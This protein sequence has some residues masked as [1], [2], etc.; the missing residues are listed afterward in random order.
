MIAL[1][2]WAPLIAGLAAPPLLAW[3]ITLGRDCPRRATRLIALAL[4]L[5]LAVEWVSLFAQE[6][7][8]GRVGQIIN[9]LEV[10]A[11]TFLS[12]SAVSGVLSY[13]LWTLLLAD[14]ARARARLR[15]VVLTLVLAVTLALQVTLSY[16]FALR[17]PLREALVRLGVV[18]QFVAVLL[19]AAVALAALIVAQVF[20][21]S[22]SWATGS[23]GAS[24]PATSETR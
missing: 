3:L 21:A 6:W 10:V 12:G 9:L 20:P 2:Q 1:Y 15:L 4:A 24:N 8:P 5:A 17:E 19:Q 23:T 7:A 16:S 18:G 22:L 11:F 14:A 13:A